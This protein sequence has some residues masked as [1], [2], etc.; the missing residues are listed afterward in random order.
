MALNLHNKYAMQPLSFT[1]FFKAV[2]EALV[3]SHFKERKTILV[4]SC[5]TVCH[6]YGVQSNLKVCGRNP[7]V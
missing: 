6:A 5:G 2:V 1:K 3:C 7:S 4:L